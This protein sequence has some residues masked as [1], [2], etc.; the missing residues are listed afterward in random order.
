VNR[1]PAPK[2]LPQTL[3]P[4]ALSD[5]PVRLHAELGRARLPVARAVGL[6]P[7]T[8][9]DLNQA[10]DSPIGLFLNGAPF[11]TGRLLVV[12]GEW[13]VRLEA[14]LGVEGPVPTDR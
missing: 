4:E 10:P 11:A 7:G 5:V 8:I 12:D 6:E 9:V 2:P 3:A 1:S 13:A 14:V